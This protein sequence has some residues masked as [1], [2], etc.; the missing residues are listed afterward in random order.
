MK[1]ML[2]PLFINQWEKDIYANNGSSYR[3]ILT[4]GQSIITSSNI[5]RTP[6][7]VA[8]TK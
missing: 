1:M 5:Y 7:M 4:A 6:N 8:E 2:I 3:M